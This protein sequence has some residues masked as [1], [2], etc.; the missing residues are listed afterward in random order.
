MAA[1]GETTD[2]RSG[3][4]MTS[5]TGRYH[6]YQKT[7][8]YFEKREKRLSYR[9]S[10]RTDD[11]DRRSFLGVVVVVVAGGRSAGAEVR[12]R[13]RAS[14]PNRT[15]PPEN[16]T[17]FIDLRW[18]AM[19]ARSPPPVR[20]TRH[21]VVAVLVVVVDDYLIGITGL[22]K[23]RGRKLETILADL[24]ISSKMA[25]TNS[26]ALFDNISPCMATYRLCTSRLSAFSDLSRQS[27]RAIVLCRRERIEALKMAKPSPRFRRELRDNSW[28]IKG[29]SD[30]GN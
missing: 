21:V 22:I 12:K 27:F 28:I 20:R 9:T 11:V 19:F 2:S 1:G 17:C 15:P 3:Y 8:E 30:N 16:V 23:T 29:S 14:A 25:R 6:H 24:L 10:A 26:H 18:A 4:I 7:T 5:P 13:R